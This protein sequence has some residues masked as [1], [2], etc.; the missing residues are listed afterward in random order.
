MKKTIKITALAFVVSFSAISCQK[1]VSDAELTTQ[2]TTA[3]SAY[4]ETSVEVKDGVAHLSGTF[5]SQ[6]DK[7]AAIA[8]IKNIKGVRDVMDMAT[9]EA[10]ASVVETVS[11]VAPEVQQKVTDAVKDF[12]AVKV[13]VVNGELTLTGEVTA[14]QARKIKMSVDALK[15]GKVNY[16]Y[17]VKK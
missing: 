9:V 16:N 15:V 14:E 12:P 8:A 11:A 1:S 6:G 13:D 3:I 5:A 2:S 7:D 10:A 17:N 4:P